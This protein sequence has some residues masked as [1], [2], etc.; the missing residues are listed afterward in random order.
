M[1]RKYLGVGLLLAVL[2]ANIVLTQYMVHQYFYE[3]YKNSMM[4]AIVN[5]L[6]FVIAFVIYKND[7]KHVEGMKANE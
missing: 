2:M 4:A 1:K 5:I 7:K 6:L 3:H